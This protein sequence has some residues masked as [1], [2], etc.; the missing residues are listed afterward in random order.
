MKYTIRVGGKDIVFTADNIT[1]AK[2]YAASKGWNPDYVVP[3]D[4]V[5]AAD[6]GVATP[7]AE[8]KAGVKAK[9]VEAR[10]TTPAPTTTSTPTTEPKAETKIE[11]KAQLA[12]AK[13]TTTT[14]TWTAA[15]TAEYEAYQAAVAT[16]L[17]PNLP[18]VSN[19]NEYWRIANQLTANEGYYFNT[20]AGSL[21][22]WEAWERHQ[23]Y[24]GQYGNI[25]DMVADNWADFIN[26]YDQYVEQTEA[27]V[28]EAGP[29]AAGFTDDQIRRYKDYQQWYYQ[30]GKPGDPFPVD[31][32][33]FIA[34]EDT[35][36]QQQA[37][38]E[39][40]AAEAEQY[41]IDPAEAARR[42]EEAYAES[43]VAAGERYRET[44]EYQ[45]QFTQWMQDQTAFSGA[46]EQ[47]AEREFPSLRSEFQATQPTLTG[48][49]TPEA[50]RA[51][52]ARREQAFKGWLTE[53]TP[54]LEQEY[55]AQRP[56][57]RG[58]RLYMQSPT[59]RTVNW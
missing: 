49:P 16:G 34:N 20:T 26:N 51:E 11:A 42:R 13:T 48:F 57:E 56:A 22:Q 47:F 44:P 38:W 27:W 33:D 18:K 55:W 9:I 46:L 54:E 5:T 29:E 37:I 53:R 1:A 59:M 19:A 40:E 2:K 58:E 52:A 50:A 43:R 3:G 12:A 17:Y 15:Q 25:E 21:D 35:Y 39:G 36:Q 14:D 8:A 4:W 31:V 45:P 41:E 28:L 10:E 7:K 6:T 32:G 24:G 23:L 30:H